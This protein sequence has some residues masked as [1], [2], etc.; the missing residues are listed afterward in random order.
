MRWISDCSSSS[1]R[2]S[3][4][5]CSMVSRGSTKTVWPEEDDAV[6]DAG[7]AAAELGLDGDDEAFA[8]HGDDVVA[9]SEPSSRRERAARRR[10]ASIA[11][12][13]RFHGAADA[14]ELGAGVVGQRAVGLDLAAQGAE[15]RGEIV[16]EEIGG[17][18]GIAGLH[19]VAGWPAVAGGEEGAPGGDA[20]DDVEEGEDFGGSRAAPAMRALSSSG[21]GS[22]RPWKSK[23]PPPVRKARNS[24]VRC[25]WAMIQ[26][27][28]AQGSS[29]RVQAR[30]SGEGCG[31]D[32]LAQRGHSSARRWIQLGA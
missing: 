6:D 30:P 31:G 26:A 9:W 19:E 21:A 13:W 1:R 23:E 18:G 27:R 15:Q 22:K 12:C 28:S 7:D 8:A 29:A 32:V 4:L 24:S 16:G 5:F 14:A 10:L 25:C 3:S 2:T 17:E 20:L 11:R